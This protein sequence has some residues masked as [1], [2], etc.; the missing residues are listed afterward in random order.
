MG[1]PNAVEVGPGL[2]YVAP[3]GTA[4]PASP[5][6]VLPSAWF[7]IGYTDT[8]HTFTSST[9][10]EPIEVA[11]ELDPIR[12]V[13]TRRDVM[14]EFSM[15]EIDTSHLSIAF[16]G[17][18]ISSPSGGFVS[19]EP[20]DLGDEERLMMFWRNDDQSRGVLWRRV[21]Q[22]GSIAIPQQKAPAKAVI[23]VQFKL[24]KPLDG[25]KLFKAWGLDTLSYT[26]P[27]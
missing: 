27:H 9:T 20:P 4:E 10:V 18:T 12:N 8:G 15:A 21:L 6:A 19:F 14:V 3:I 7:P 23:P 13:A 26:D 5:T 25:S 1:N 22:S 16:N 2:L 24:E 11:E 17:G